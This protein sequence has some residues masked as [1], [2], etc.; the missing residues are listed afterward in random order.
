MTLP[1]RADVDMLTVRELAGRWKTSEDMVLREIA[2][3]RLHAV[4]LGRQWR[5]PVWAA[6]EWAERVEGRESNVRRLRP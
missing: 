1:A 2:G 6:R 4:R 5:V 3:G